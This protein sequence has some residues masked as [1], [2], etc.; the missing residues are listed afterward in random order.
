[1]DAQ[2]TNCKWFFWGVFLPPFLLS[3]KFVGEIFPSI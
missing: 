1:M 3:L 2:L